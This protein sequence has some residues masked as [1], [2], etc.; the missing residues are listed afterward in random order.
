MKVMLKYI[1][2]VVFLPFLLFVKGDL[3]L[4]TFAEITK[5]DQPIKEVH[6]KVSQAVSAEGDITFTIPVKIV[7]NQDSF[8]G[9]GLKVKLFDAEYNQIAE[10]Q[11]LDQTVK[12]TIPSRYAAHQNFHVVSVETADELDLEGLQKIEVSLEVNEAHLSENLK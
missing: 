9:N 6:A 2:T 5:L 11:I 8:S 4:D 7:S 1:W 3:S 10:S 12:F